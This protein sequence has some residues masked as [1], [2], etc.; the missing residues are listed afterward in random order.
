MRLPAVLINKYLDLG[1]GQDTNDKPRWLT[2]LTSVTQ[3]NYY[4]PK[5]TML[6]YFVQVWQC[7]FEPTASSK[8]SKIVATCGGNTVCFIDVE[9]GQ[10]NKKY[11]SS[12][13]RCVC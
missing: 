10:L 9:T 8:S 7:S 13:S 4:K 1:G 3:A 5:L 11:Y 2:C 12:N 6:F